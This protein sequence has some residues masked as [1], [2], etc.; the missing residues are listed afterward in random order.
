[1]FFYL[2]IYF[3]FHL[4]IYDSYLHVTS[5][6]C[7]YRKTTYTFIVKYHRDSRKLSVFP[8]FSV[9]NTAQQ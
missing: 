7:K 3:T 8:P 9:L 2:S 4:P 6:L 1:M 5:M